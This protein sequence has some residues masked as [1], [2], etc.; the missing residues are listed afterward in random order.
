MMAELIVVAPIGG[1]WCVQRGMS[2]PWTFETKDQAEWSARRLGE[3][4]AEAGAAAEVRVL[5]ADGRVGS[6]FVLARGDGAALPA[7]QMA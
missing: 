7:P 2:E 3:L 5:L 1:G 4:L 6:R